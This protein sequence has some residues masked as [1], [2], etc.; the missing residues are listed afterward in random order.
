LKKLCIVIGTRP[1]LI[2]V[3]CLVREF[4]LRGYRDQC[5]VINTAQHRELL[6]P[7]WSLFGIQPDITLDVMKHGQSLSELHARVL[8]QFQITIEQMTEKVGGVLAQG[9]TTTVLGTAMVSFYNRIPFYHLEAGLRSFNMQ[10]PY[11]EEFNRKATSQISSFHFCPTE[12]SATNLLNEGIDADKIAVVGN[13]VIDALEFIKMDIRQ[14]PEFE[15]SVLRDRIKDDDSIVLIT[16]HRR[17]NQGLNLNHILTAVSELAVENPHIIFIWT[18]HP[19]PNVRNVVMSHGLA[20]LSNVLLVEPLS[21]YDIMRI[22][23]RACMA[24]SD[25]GGIQEEAPSFNVPVMVLREF[26]ERP[27]GIA[28]GASELVGANHGLIKQRFSH[29]LRHSICLVKNPYGDGKAAPRVAEKLIS[30]LST[31]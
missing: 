20:L 24:I 3:G 15:N 7:Y 27:E 10:N 23:S 1:E 11:P 22:L 25:S 18:I 6:D 21:Y 5:I 26:T 31:T 9:D 29:Y 30:L 12:T 28:I 8:S 14:Q 4:E 17:E 19:S 16:C 13:T 2:K